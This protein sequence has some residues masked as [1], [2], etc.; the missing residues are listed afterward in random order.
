[1]PPL[2][3]SVIISYLPSITVPILAI[4]QSP[5][6]IVL[7]ATQVI[8][9]CSFLS[10]S[11]LIISSKVSL[12][13]RSV[14]IIFGERSPKSSFSFISCLNPSEHKKY[15]ASCSNLYFLYSGS[16]F[17][18][19]PMHWSNTFR[20]ESVSSSSID[21][22]NTLIYLATRYWSFVNLVTLSVTLYTLESPTFAT[23]ISF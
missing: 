9:S 17:C 1:M 12:I 23:Y 16:S 21:N 5:Y 11:K 10:L 3:I 22:V 13:E 6:A 4:V 20:L 19:A 14:L 15:T 7:K 8:L 2:P 18:D